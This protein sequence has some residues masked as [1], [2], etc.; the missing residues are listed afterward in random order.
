[1]KQLVKN[2]RLV[3]N[4]R[5][6]FRTKKILSDSD[7]QIKIE[8]PSG[9]LIYDFIK[10]KNITNVLEIGTWNGLGSTIVL[11][12]ALKYKNK[13]FSL[14]SIE[15]DKIAYKNAKKNLKD[16]KEVNLVLGRIIEISDLPDE[17]SI[18]F[19]KHN[20]NPKNIEW[21][22]QDI[23]RYKKT[24]NIFS[25][26]KDSY[27]FIL[28]DGGEFSTFAEFKKLYKKTYYFCLD[29]IYTYKQYE[30]LQYIE[31]FPELFELIESIEDLSIYK[32]RKN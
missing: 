17:K 30:V 9:K 26:L 4:I 6:Y 13:P 1:M 27:D 25:D 12:E 5:N 16:K 2:L 31:K 24:K 8:N 19:K 32:V 7:G 10:N 20:L 18:D 3:K 21:F 15:T 22:Y 29:D 28:F 23:R 14:T 11:Y